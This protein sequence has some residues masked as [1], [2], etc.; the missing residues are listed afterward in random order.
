METVTPGLRAR[1]SRLSPHS[2]LQETLD[3]NSWPWG[4]A[5]HPLV[6]TATLP[7]RPW[8]PRGLE[9]VSLR[10]PGYRPGKL[11]FPESEYISLSVLVYLQF[12]KSF[13]QLTRD[14]RVMVSYVP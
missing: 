6:C 1:P 7:A 14:S 2:C 13:V 12:V 11:I 4:A 3:L 5:S 8:V 10:C 9:G